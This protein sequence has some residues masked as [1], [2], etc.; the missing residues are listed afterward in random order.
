MFVFIELHRAFKA[1]NIMYFIWKGDQESGIPGFYTYQ[2]Y[3]LPVKH[4]PGPAFD[5]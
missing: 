5:S 4:I 3:T 1:V 2:T